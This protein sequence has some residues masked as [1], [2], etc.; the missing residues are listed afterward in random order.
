MP[1]TTHDK[2]NSLKGI[3][4]A[5]KA[6]KDQRS[7]GAE[8]VEELDLAI[9]GLIDSQAAMDKLLSGDE[10]VLEE[11]VEKW[12]PVFERIMEQQM[13][14]RFAAMKGKFD[15]NTGG[16]ILARVDKTG[17]TLEQKMLMTKSELA[18]YFPG[19][20]VADLTTLQHLWD[21]AMLVGH[22]MFWSKKNKGDVHGTLKQEV[23]SSRAYKQWA[24]ATRAMDTATTTEGL[25]LVPTNFSAQILAVVAVTLKVAATFVSMTMPTSP[26]K[27]PVATSDDVG[28]K[29]P[30]QLT[31]N[32]LTEANKISALTPATTNVT[33]TAQKPGA[34]AVFSEEINEDSIIAIVP[35]LREKL[36]NSIGN[37]I[38]RAVIDGDTDG[39]HQDDDVS[40]A[41][42]A[43]KLWNGIRKDVDA[44]TNGIDLSTLNL[45]NLRALRQALTP[46][47][48]EDAE[49]LVYAVSVANMLR[50]LDFAEFVTV[51][52]FGPNATIL[53][54]QV[55]RIDNTPV[56]TSKYV[57]TDVAAT[58][59]NTSGGPN[60]KAIILLYSRNGYMIGQRRTLTIKFGESIWTDQGI[61]VATQ[62]LDFQK[63]RG[64]NIT[65]AIGK[66]ITP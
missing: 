29:A 61:L 25:E 12:K 6:I 58:G 33:F 15:L 27:L 55:G 8:K 21:E 23:M 63:T 40:A 16:Q 38:E 11:Q 56:L 31:D 41:T 54:G 19:D 48:A 46:A 14:A 60:T 35:F 5:L 1:P 45:T 64:S 24:A 7:A 32:F 37:A 59:V 50:F 9:K 44:P 36:G 47:Y 62:R 26:F 51:D 10:A 22:I 53:R 17:L 20:Q 66:N 30:E 52:K 42:D 28:F 4:D 49:T 13:E 65:A 2:E 34:L 39:T 43:R 57:R 3:H 18:R